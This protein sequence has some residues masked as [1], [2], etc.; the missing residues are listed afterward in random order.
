MRSTFVRYAAR[1]SSRAAAALLGG[2]SALGALAAST[3]GCSLEICEVAACNTDAAA[4]GGGAGQGGGA[5]GGATC[6]PA[7]TAGANATAECVGGACVYTCEAGFE[8]CDADPS[9]CEVDL[10]S[11]ENCGAC[12]NGCVVECS[13][14][15]GAL[16]CNDPVEIAAGGE[17]TCVRKASGSVFCWGR[18]QAAQIGAGTNTN[19][20]DLPQKVAL[21]Q[22]VRAVALAAGLDQSCIIDH[23]SK[24]WC[25]G[26]GLEAPSKLPREIPNSSGV[27][28]VSVW[29]QNGAFL[30]GG[31]AFVF[32][33]GFL[34]GAVTGPSSL[35]AVGAGGIARGGDHGCAIRSG[36]AVHCWGRNDYGQLGLPASTEVLPAPT[37]AI[38][39]LTATVVATGSDHSCAIAQGGQLYCWGRAIDFAQVGNDT[40]ANV[41]GPQPVL[42]D[43]QRVK[44]G[45]HSSGALRNGALYLWGRNDA[46]QV[47]SSTDT[48][49]SIPTP[50]GDVPNVVDFALGAQHTCV[51]DAAAQV[52]CYGANEFGQLG[53]GSTD[54]RVGPQLVT[55]PRD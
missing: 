36:G 22:G 4:G 43:V 41:F 21:G 37:A 40:F 55:I 19:T 53:V 42:A 28:A 44:L 15:D 23:Q 7:C 10:A 50:R 49:I 27:T 25:W 2:L 48:A 52:R 32:E 13:E 31:G 24:L 33:V 47:S 34:D 38:P 26:R 51:L 5:G 45:T 6:E 29:G 9:D 12:G 16:T 14:I 1:R 46:R 30:L 54:P 39:G 20:E 18:N 17:H 35:F 8:S 11:K 3:A